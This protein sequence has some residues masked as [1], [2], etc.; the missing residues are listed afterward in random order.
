MM[1]AEDRLADGLSDRYVIERRL[2]RGG[3][4]TVFQARDLRHERTVAIKVLNDDVAAGIG[5]ARF[6]REIRIAAGL[7]HPHILS[8]YD[9]GEIAGMLYYVMP[10]AEGRSLR[11][12]LNADGQLPVAEALRIAR[13]VAAALDYAHRRK[14]VHRD[15]KPENILFQ[16]ANAL[17]ADFGIG[18]VL[19]DAGGVTQ[20]GSFIGTPAYMSPE[21]ALGD[22]EVDARTDI[23]SLGCVLYEMLSG[24][25]PFPGPTAQAMLA[26]RLVAAAPS[27][28]RTRDVP[29]AVS[30]AVDRA[31][32]RNATE[33]FA[34]AAE[35]ADCLVSQ[36]ATRRRGKRKP[37]SIAV[38]PFQFD[39]QGHSGL[40]YLAEGLAESLIQR[41]SELPRLKVMARGTVFQ[42]TDPE[43]EPRAVGRELRVDAVVSGH[44]R[45][46]G[47]H[48]VLGV[49]LI[50]TED[51]SHLWGARYE[52]TD[53]DVLSLQDALAEEI[54]SGLR[55]QLT[56]AQ[57]KRLARRPTDD[58]A[59][60]ECY[61]RGRFHLEKR[62]RD[63]LQ[64][65]VQFFE[66]AISIDAAYALAYAG[67][68]ETYT[69]LG[70]AGYSRVPMDVMGVARRGALRAVELDDQ[71]A[72]AHASLGWLRFRFDWDWSGAEAE[73]RRAIAL[74]PAYSRAHHW[75]ALLLTA[76]G[77]ASA[78]LQ[79]V[80]R[81]LEGD[82]LSAVVNTARGRVLHFG[83]RYHEA[84]EQ[85]RA[86]MRLDAGF[87]SVHFD[88]GMTLAQMERLDEAISEFEGHRAGLTER[89][90]MRAI[91][92]NFYGQVG[93][94]DDALGIVA[95][96]RALPGA[97]V[98]AAFDLAI[99]F[100]GLGDT[101]AV[102]ASLE[103]CLIVR[104]SPIV[105]LK[106]EPLF[107]PYRAHPRFHAILSALGLG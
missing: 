45:Q 81:A 87:V 82:P 33:R 17:V 24:K 64:L 61:L 75:L 13:E 19:G 20:T 98:T 93:R 60:F 79:S 41:L 56:G 46:I 66:K 5:A 44:L 11:D 9:S 7:T 68:A 47:S 78:A 22:D 50:A 104:N 90:T 23:Y 21:Q 107:D 91:L 52:K 12:R 102:L 99:A 54:V 49:E 86:A 77:D 8:V 106:V 65:A 55:L 27:I 89:P 2:G 96:L 92:A 74:A 95:E 34:S 38:L 72:E 57:R 10:V 76:R 53:V 51:G 67:L 94:R 85:F 32:A 30:T 31:L 29:D 14:V 4:A 6:L 59:A 40:D 83:K 58:P 1:H 39:R 36:S 84:V 69:L 16:E 62:S 3:M 70:T 26:Q 71:L 48:F 97:E 88:L 80:D 35:F 42:F 37:A 43:V 101:E 15:V 73:L 105:F 63:D 25:L 28:S 100:A 103:R 18:K